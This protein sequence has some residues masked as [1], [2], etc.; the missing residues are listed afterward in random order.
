MA[1]EIGTVAKSVSFRFNVGTEE[2]QPEHI[3]G[4][5]VTIFGKNPAS[6]AEVK[7]LKTVPNDGTFA[8]AFPMNYSGEVY[9]EL[10][11]SDE[12]EDSQTLP[13]GEAPEVIPPEEVEGDPPPGE[14]TEE[15]PVEEAPAE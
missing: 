12:G 10:H 8:L 9:I 15:T 5:K 3:T 1:I 2:G 11:G 6:D 14:G 4:D 7:E 13:V